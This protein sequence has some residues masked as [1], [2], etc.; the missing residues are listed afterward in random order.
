MIY[1]ITYLLLALFPA[2]NENLLLVRELYPQIALSKSKFEKFNQLLE[3][4]NAADNTLEAYGAA[5]KM[6][7]ANYVSNPV[8]KLNYF[9]EGKEKLEKCIAKSPVNTELIYLRFT[10]QS[11]APSILGYTKNLDADKS[12]LLK[13]YSA[14]KNKNVRENIVSFLK[15]SDQLTEKEKQNLK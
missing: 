11:K 6:I 7:E 12:Y 3:T 5:A 4:S 10:I 8:T 15:Q 13:N 2:D 14:V 1:Y 9:N